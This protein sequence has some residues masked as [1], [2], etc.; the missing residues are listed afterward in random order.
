LSGDPSPPPGPILIVAPHQDDAALSC[1]ALIE[2]PGPVDVLTVFTGLPES[3]RRG[4]WDVKTG[5][6]GSHESVP[7][8]NEEERRALEPSVRRLELLGLA[9][10]QHLEGPRT[11]ADAESLASRVTAWFSVEGPSATVAV[12]AGAGW[13]PGFI[14]RQLVRR[15]LITQPG[16]RP[17]P[18][19]EYVRDVVLN[20]LGTDDATLLLYEELPYRWGGQADAEAER[21]G[22]VRGVR[23]ELVALPVDRE[24]KAVRIALYASQVPYISTAR[25]RVDDPSVLPAD[26]RYWRLGKARDARTRTPFGR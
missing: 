21:V 19:H 8:R 13:R 17:H 7:A 1:A 11:A 5:F 18:G 6:E 12:P 2:A 22:A 24:A 23:T 14:A 3:P 20:A 10:G 16:P 15:G 9:E 25:G 26:E 4:W